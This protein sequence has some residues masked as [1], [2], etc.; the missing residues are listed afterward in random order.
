MTGTKVCYPRQNSRTAPGGISCTYCL[1]VFTTGRKPVSRPMSQGLSWKLV[2]SEVGVVVLMYHA[3]VQSSVGNP[4][5][6][7]LQVGGNRDKEGQG[8]EEMSWAK[9]G[10]RR[11]RSKPQDGEV[12][13]VNV[14]LT[15]TL[16]WRP[17][18]RCLR[19]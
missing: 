18:V 7:L 17:G 8:K 19:T 12:E 3:P 2:N 14:P 5:R 4:P 9:K 1:S 13:N 16:W 6:W 10:G 11:G 15:G